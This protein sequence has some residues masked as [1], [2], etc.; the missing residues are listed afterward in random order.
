MN[1]FLMFEPEMSLTVDED[2]DTVRERLA[3]ASDGLAELHVNEKKVLVRA[4]AVRYAQ[5]QG[6]GQGG[7]I[8][9]KTS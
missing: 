9:F 6:T 2:V 3:N 7:G 4:A 1:S 5:E 8:G